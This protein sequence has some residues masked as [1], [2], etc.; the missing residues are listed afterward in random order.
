MIATP[1]GERPIADLSAGDLVYSAKGGALVEVPLVTLDTGRVLEISPGHPIADGRFFSHLRAGELRD[2]EGE[3]S[4][5]RARIREGIVDVR[6]GCKQAAHE[7][8]GRCRHP[9]LRWG[10]DGR[11]RRGRLSQ[12]SCFA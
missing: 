6:R 4:S 2:S 12:G 9:N 11:A 10:T 3:L 1:S 5:N 8:W 7:G